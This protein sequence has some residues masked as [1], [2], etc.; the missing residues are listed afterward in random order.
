MNN[1]TSIS[2]CNAKSFNKSANSLNIM[3]NNKDKEKDDISN[4]IHFNAGNSICSDNG[5]L[6]NN[7]NQINNNTNII[8]NEIIKNNSKSSSL[9]SN[10]IHDIKVNKERNKKF[11]EINNSNNNYNSCKINKKKSTPNLH[12]SNNYKNINNSKLKEFEKSKSEIKTRDNSYTENYDFAQIINNN[13][14]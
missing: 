2:F 3:K 10:A 5:T 4:S 9:D 12:L 14:V 6:N 8:S 7:N 1:N 13:K 11:V